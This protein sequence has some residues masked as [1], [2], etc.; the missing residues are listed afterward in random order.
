MITKA[1]ARHGG[2]PLGRRPDPPA[3]FFIA[4]QFYIGPKF[5]LDAASVMIFLDLWR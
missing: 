3:A 5:L 1:I 2:H 4:G